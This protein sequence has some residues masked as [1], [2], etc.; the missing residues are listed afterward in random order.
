V[1]G[2]AGVSRA[3]VG[4]GCPADAVV[5]GAGVG[6]CE[7]E[8]GGEKAAAGGG[9]EA[10]VGA[11]G[12]AGFG[13]AVT[14][15]AGSLGGATGAPAGPAEGAEAVV[16]AAG[17]VSIQPRLLAIGSSGLVGVFGACAETGAANASPPTKINA[18]EKR[19]MAE[20]LHT[21]LGPDKGAIPYPSCQ[22]SRP[23]LTL[24]VN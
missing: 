18:Q 4:V 24:I 8:A 6:G 22:F 21:G 13:A 3:A 10:T 17:A 16:C 7:P 11:A 19:F 23:F 20:N 5:C 12:A 1:L 2:P 15:G 9:A 14:A